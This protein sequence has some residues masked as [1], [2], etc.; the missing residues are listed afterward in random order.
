MT[1]HRSSNIQPS[2]IVAPCRFERDRSPPVKSALIRFLKCN[3]LWNAAKVEKKAKCTVRSRCQPWSWKIYRNTF[4]RKRKGGISQNTE[5]PNYHSINRQ[6]FSRIK[7]TRITLQPTT[8]DHFHPLN[9]RK[10]V[11]TG[12]GRDPRLMEPGNGLE[13]TIILGWMWITCSGSVT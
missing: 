10:C 4:R 7:A 6:L 1:A 12:Y 13:A 11:C 5:C 2:G 3:H 8:D 9:F